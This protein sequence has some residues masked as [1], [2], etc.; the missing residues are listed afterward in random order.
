[1]NLNSIL[2]ILTA[3]TREEMASFINDCNILDGLKYHRLKI[4]TA[5]TSTGIRRIFINI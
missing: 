2:F 3:T 4:S 1:M 5:W